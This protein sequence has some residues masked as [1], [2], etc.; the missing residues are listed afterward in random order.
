MQYLQAWSHVGAVGVQDL[1][2]SS[3]KCLPTLSEELVTSPTSVVW[4]SKPAW[5]NC[6]FRIGQ[7][8]YLSTHCAAVVGGGLWGVVLSGQPLN[9]EQQP[10]NRETSEGTLQHGSD[11]DS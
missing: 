11:G 3:T 2:Q 1:Q 6:F 8:E 5:S 9:A 4:Q 10:K 7:V